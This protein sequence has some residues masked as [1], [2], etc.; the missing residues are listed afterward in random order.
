MRFLDHDEAGIVQGRGQADLADDI[1]PCSGMLAGQEVGGRKCRGPQIL[2][3]DDQ[4]SL[5]ET[6]RKIPGGV[7][8]V[9]GQHQEAARGVNPAVDQIGGTREGDVA[10]EQYAIFV[11]Q[12]AFDVARSPL[13]GYKPTAER[14]V[15]QY[16]SRTSAGRTR[17]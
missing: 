11:G 9:V 7:A 10:L 14:R 8:R 17:Q 4:P 5:L 3:G 12:P 15:L 1:E 2:L 13:H 6:G 16:P